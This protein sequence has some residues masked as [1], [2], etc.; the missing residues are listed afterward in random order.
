MPQGKTFDNI[1]ETTFNTPLV[2]LNRIVPPG[3]ATVLLKL[4]FFNPLSS[5]KDRSAASAAKRRS[6]SPPVA[7]RA[8]P[9][10]SWPPPR[11]TS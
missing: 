8:L 7:T 5:V 4:E 10:P 3:T 2:K 9:W 1:I 6:S 11:G